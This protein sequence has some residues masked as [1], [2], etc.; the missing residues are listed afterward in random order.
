MG[1]ADIVSTHNPCLLL[2]IVIMRQYQRNMMTKMWI[3]TPLLQKSHQHIIW[4]VKF[5]NSPP[6]SYSSLKGRVPKKGSAPGR[7][8]RYYRKKLSV[9]DKWAF[10]K[11]S[12]NYRYRKEDIWE[13]SKNYRYRKMCIQFH[14][15]NSI[16]STVPKTRK[17][18]QRSTE[19][20][21]KRHIIFIKRP[22]K[23]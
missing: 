19:E 8:G 9:A 10:F 11:L 23:A 13:L 2:F 3:H 21:K 6:S 14:P 5:S 15:I 17:R 16:E 1:S 22:Q 18:P 4:L 12:L 20:T 7:G